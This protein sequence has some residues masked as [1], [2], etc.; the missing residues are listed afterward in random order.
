MSAR[1]G[2]YGDDDPRVNP[3]G[4]TI[5]LGRPLGMSGA[6]LRRDQRRGARLSRARYAPIAT[7]CVEE[8]GLALRSSS[9]R[10]IERWRSTEAGVRLGR[11]VSGLVLFSPGHPKCRKPALH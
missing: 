3:N 11:A 9:K 1:L 4:G 8:V 2:F 5:A 10:P 7:M 6:R